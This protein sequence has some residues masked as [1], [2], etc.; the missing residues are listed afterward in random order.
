MTRARVRITWADGSQPVDQVMEVAA[1]QDFLAPTKAAGVFF[2]NS[3]GGR[4]D[5]FVDGVLTYW[6]SV[7]VT[8]HL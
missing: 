1:V 8:D 6:G 7:D 5:R 4:L 3:R 2:G